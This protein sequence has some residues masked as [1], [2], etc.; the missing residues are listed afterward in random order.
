[1]TDSVVTRFAPRRP[2]SSISEAPAPRC[3]IWLYAKK[4]GGKMLLRIE[5][6]DR[7][8]ST[9]PAISAILDGLRW[10]ELDWDGDVIYQFS[11]AAVTRSRGIPCSP[12]AGP[13][14]L[15][16]AGGTDGDARERA[17]PRAAP[18]STMACGGT[19]ILRAP[20]A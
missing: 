13:I 7:E 19:A 15:C 17:A 10:L 1:M 16:H 12:A 11:R 14:L 2:A 3:S 18:A 5:D 20:A 6:T 8:R 9:E 4:H